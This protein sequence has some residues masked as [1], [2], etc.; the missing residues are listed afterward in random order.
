MQIKSNKQ[1]RSYVISW[2]L[3]IVGVIVTIGGFGVYK[4][5]ESYQLSSFLRDKQAQVNIVANFI[6][7]EQHYWIKDPRSL[8]KLDN[9]RLSHQFLNATKVEQGQQDFFSVNY[10][11]H[12]KQFKYAIDHR[13][14]TEDLIQI[15]TP[16]VELKLVK[17][18]SNELKIYLS[19]VAYQSLEVGTADQKTVLN[20][21]KEDG[22][23][24]LLLDNEV[25]LE[26][27]HANK[28]SAKFHG[29]LLDAEHPQTH[30]LVKLSGNKE[31]PV[32]FRFISKGGYLHIAGTELNVPKTLK[33]AMLSSLMSVESSA[34]GGVVDAEEYSST[35]IF[36]P[37]TNNKNKPNGVVVL[38]VTNSSLTKLG[39]EMLASMF[40][41]FSL[42]SIFLMSAAI[43]FAR[44]ITNPLE[45][46]TIAIARLIH[47]DYNFKLSS[48]RF[49]SFG[50][51]ATQFNAMLTRLQKSR[52]ELIQLNKSYSRFVPHQLLKQLSSSGVG[53]ISLGDSCERNMTIL[54]CD[55][56][57]FTTLSE[58][59]SPA[60]NFRFINRYLSQIAP[61]INKHGGIIDK[62]MGDGIM[63]L[64]PNSADDALRAAIQ[65]LG[66]L[67]DY[68]KILQN[69]KLSTIEIGLG[70]HSGRTM[71][72]TVG[73]QSRMDATVISDTVNAAARVESMT[74]AFCTN[75]LITEE[76]K[77]ELKDLS[78]YRMR[79][80]AA[81]RIQ[82]KSKPVTMYEVFNND[83]LSL[84]KEKA[85][86]QP[87]MIKAWRKYKEGD[88]AMAVQM[89][90]RLIEK[91]PHDKSLFAL[92]ERCQSGRL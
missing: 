25:V 17:R 78:K 31:I 91:S 32:N 42:L 6:D 10:D 33:N 20:L 11:Y 16:E 4:S 75:I 39:D 8:L 70:L 18:G 41:S 64:F 81:C 62:Y 5:A 52:N 48:K 13:V 53:D 87:M 28:F 57:G 76:T 27:E 71:L 77:R 45:Q 21:Q 55:I 65:M 80:I 29:N 68:N 26:M 67:A 84:Q 60:A 12:K 2:F 66:S 15:T 82:G 40:L 38:Q 61:V 46:L 88:A 85:Q 24:R 86:N 63:A 23:T 49:G 90:Q 73:T 47:N 79:Y 54:F 74:K 34:K 7:G 1:F 36:S 44:K 9:Q 83:P 89:Y 19:D 51:L 37:I 14:A 35:Y 43:F 30:T 58:S 72:G 50:Y 92:I 56:R 69:K 59:L 22:V 3:A